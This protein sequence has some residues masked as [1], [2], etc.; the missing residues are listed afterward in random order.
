MIAYYTQERNPDNELLPLDCPWVSWNY[1]E[2]LG[3]PDNAILVTNEEYEAIYNTY[4]PIILREKDRMTMLNRSLV[5]DKIIG[6][7]ATENKER[8]RQGLWTVAQLVALTEE[9]DF[10]AIMNDI[11][12]LSY[13]LAQQKIM[14]WVHPLITQ[15]MRMGIVM[16]L[17]DNL[18]L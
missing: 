15:E 8:I 18:F 2:A 16:K 17:Q 6:E 12:G 13:E 3:L 1:D 7:I 14:A 11:Q 5:K 4:L 10:K 9:P